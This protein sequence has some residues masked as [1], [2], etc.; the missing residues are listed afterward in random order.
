MGSLDR[1]GRRAWLI[2]IGLVAMSTCVY[3]AEREKPSDLVKVENIEVAI[4]AA[5]PVVLLKARG[6]AIPVFVDH[7]V[8]E[9]IHAALTNRRLP[10]P[11]THDLMH[12]ILTSFGGKVT[13]AVVSLHGSTYHGELSVDLGDRTKV[14]DSR[15]SDA[16]ALAIHFSAPILVSAELLEGSGQEEADP[17]GSQRL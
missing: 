13:R 15:S 7:T 12:T 4:S 8:A 17:P 3:A 14:F 10:R 16:I 2:G 6:K 5:G 11:L 1:R 9:S